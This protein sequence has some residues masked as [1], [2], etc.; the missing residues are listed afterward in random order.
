MGQ[1]AQI[2][3]IKAR[4]FID[5]SVAAQIVMESAISMSKMDPTKIYNAYV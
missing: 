3:M 4:G 5:P 1:S 2:A